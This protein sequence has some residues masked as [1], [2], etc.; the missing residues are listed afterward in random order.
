M[1]LAANTCFSVATPIARAAIV[2]GLNPTGLLVVRMALATLLLG[3]TVGVTSPGLLRADRRCFWIATAAGLLNAVSMLGYFWGLKRIEAS[4]A[5]MIIAISPIAVLSLLALRGE[6]VTYRHAIRLGLALG[7]VYLLIGPGGQVD[8]LGVLGV[9]VA[10]VGS[11]CQLVLIQWY[12]TGYDARQVTFYV[13]VAMTFG[14][15]VIWWVEGA[16]PTALALGRSGWLAAIVL[17]F[18]S[19]YASRL[20]LFGAVS[21]IGGGQVAM[22]SPV[23]TLLTIFWSFLFLGERLSPIQ[24]VGGLLILT[25][26]MLAIKR[27]RIA[28]LRPRWRLWVK[29]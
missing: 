6:R 5:A 24:W 13:L 17:A 15:C 20:L 19:T 10:I 12:L 8:L 11:A 2:D 28:R 16:D 23:E 25:S 4:M 7:G 29:S 1:A 21:R 9:V 26:A 18:V 27:L 3:F 22:L 14:I